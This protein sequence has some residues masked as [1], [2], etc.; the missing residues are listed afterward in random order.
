MIDE[1]GR[2]RHLELYTGL[3]AEQCRFAIM[4]LQLAMSQLDLPSDQFSHDVFWYHVHGFL[5]ATANI[6]KALWPARR[7]S[8]KS[9]WAS[10][11]D[12][13]R[14]YLGV[15]QDSLL[16]P[17]RTFR[18]HFEHFDER[19]EEWILASERGNLMDRFIGPPNAVVGLDQRNEILRQ[20]DQATWALRFRD[21]MYPLKPLIDEITALLARATR[22]EQPLWL[23]RREEPE[24]PASLHGQQEGS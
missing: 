20:Y 16:K 6:S 22:L 24:R 7:R 5:T 2:Q 14:S 3:V 17:P 18:D 19:I 23:R 13:L 10:R 8:S 15:V 9:A 21:D 1:R 11:G 4:A 12:D